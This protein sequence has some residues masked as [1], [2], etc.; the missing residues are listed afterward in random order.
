MTENAL[1]IRRTS[2]TKFTR[3]KN[4]FYSV[5]AKN[6]SIENI[7][8]KF[9]ELTD[10]W[11]TVE[12][13][14]DLYTI[15]LDDDDAYDKEEAWINELQEI[16]TEASS[17]YNTCLSENLRK[18]KEDD[19]HIKFDGLNKKKASLETMFKSSVDQIMKLLT[20]DKKE[21]IST[22]TL[23]K[24]EHDLVMIFQDCKSIHDEIIALPL[25]Q[26]YIEDEIEWLRRLHAQY[27]D[28]SSQIESHS[29]DNV[30]NTRFKETIHPLQLEKVKIPS[31][32]GN[33]RKYPQFKTYFKKHVLSVIIETSAPYV[34][35]S[36][37]SGD[38][39][40][41]VKSTD[42]NLEE[43]WERL[44]RKYGDPTK[45]TDVVIN[46]IQNFKSDSIKEGENRKLL[47][48]ITVV[49]DGYRDLQRVG[50]EAEITTTSSVSIIERMLP[51]DIKKE[52]S[53]IVCF[54][55][56][57]I[58]RSNRFPSLLTFLLDQRKIIEYETAEL[59]ATNQTVRGLTHY[60]AALQKTI[61]DVGNK[62]LTSP[63]KCLIHEKG[64]HWTSECKVF[65]AKPV[66]E[67]KQLLKMKGAC[68]SC[69]KPGHRSRDCRRKKT[70]GKNSCNERHHPTLHED[71]P[72]TESV[73]SNEVLGSAIACNTAEGYSC[74]LQVQKIKS[75]RGW[76]NVMWDSA[77]SLCF[78]TNNKAKAEKLKGEKVEL[79]I[80]KVGGRTERLQSHKYSIKLI[81]LDGNEVHFD[82]YGI[83]KITNNVH[84]V[85]VSYIAK[86][87]IHVVSLK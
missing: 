50:L 10:A 78:I 74:L 36:C 52:W 69:L 63:P 43:M 80:V 82:V 64:M 38:P 49:E 73:R 23:R 87:F 19:M 51:N 13:K 32:D 1:N 76:V 4:D 83:D 40:E 18:I 25:E 79:S 20:T 53:K 67:R 57:P 86:L 17:I 47:E 81:D 54:S 15:L 66:E 46:A 48:F 44:D 3:K 41:C 65:L 59:R 77:A 16:Y 56:E 33:I 24:N 30:I 58:N 2:K 60:T 37:L 55:V 14:H 61:E 85:D 26:R 84:N 62:G 11:Q 75:R 9:K 22:R 21:K 12:G 68:W 31:F 5:I 27:S 29:E 70:C 6:E 42:D 7:K 28:T 72:T 35:R 34:L 45:I 8:S 39:L 71:K